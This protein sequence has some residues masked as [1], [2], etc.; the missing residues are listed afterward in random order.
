MRKAAHWLL[1]RWYLPVLVLGAIVAFIALRKR[2]TG[3]D[4]FQGVKSELDAIQAGTEAR[5]MAVELGTEQALEH[6]RDKYQAK[7]Q[8]LEAKQQ[9]E[10]QTLENDPVALAKYLARLTQ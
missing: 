10:V 5:N 9:A 2:K 4:P 8:T 1:D 7:L 6:V 3:V